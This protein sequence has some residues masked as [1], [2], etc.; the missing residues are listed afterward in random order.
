MVAKYFNKGKGRTG[1]V[2]YV[3]DK[4]RVASGEAILLRGD[5]Y[6]TAELIK[7]NNNEHKYRSGV[8]TFTEQDLN[9][10]IKQ[11]IMDSFEKNT[12]AGLEKYQYNILWVEHKD[13]DK[14][15]LHFVIPRLE[16]STGKAFNPHWHKA[17][18]DR[19]IL[20]QD[21]QNAKYNL[22]NPYEMER[23]NTLQIP[24]Q[25]DNRSKAKEE[26]HEVV[27][28]GVSKGQLQNRD[29]I[30]EFLENSGLEVKRS[31][32]GQL[33][34][35]YIA[36]KAPEDKDYIR[37][38][39]AYYNESFTSAAEVARELTAREQKHTFTTPEQLREAEQQLAEAIFKKSEYNISKYRSREQKQNI[40]Q[41]V[42]INSVSNTN[43]RDNERSVHTSTEV[44][45]TAKRNAIKENT[46]I[47]GVEHTRTAESNE[48]NGREVRERD[49]QAGQTLLHQNNRGIEDENRT[50]TDTR[51]AITEER[52]R[53]ERELRQRNQAYS[54]AREARNELFRT[55]KESADAVREQST[56][57]SSRQQ[58]VKREHNEEV[59]RVAE[60]ISRYSR[61]F[62]AVRKYSK[63]F[64]DT[65]SNARELLKGEFNKCVNAWNKLEYRLK[66]T[67]EQIRK[68]KD[69]KELTFQYVRELK[70]SINRSIEHNN[71]QV[72]QNT[73]SRGMSR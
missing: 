53:A 60:P 37:L 22:S 30:V 73:R 17:D 52:E 6:I 25:W 21:I 29:Q 8:L 27:I 12:F 39:G 70:Q 71:E 45:R 47:N 46:H 41:N 28:Q 14:T 11:E 34:K 24:K 40:N 7:T 64:S 15:E 33:P 49:E 4:E 23:A 38:K 61:F 10:N 19:L 68:P 67:Q 56:K 72:R 1:P 18:Q 35:G 51:T 62:G 2:E 32:K 66:D 26:I 65:I 55:L 3:L 31:K 50:R 63:Q 69:E 13:K 54:T 5:A 9:P 42:R 48:R 20:W 36:V 16:L 44:S 59:D 58:T 43:N 57:D